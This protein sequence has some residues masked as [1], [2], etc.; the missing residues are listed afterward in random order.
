[1]FILWGYPPWI[2]FYAFMLFFL[3]LSI[4][5]AVVIASAWRAWADREDRPPQNAEISLKTEPQ[6][7]GTD[8]PRIRSGYLPILLLILG[9]VWVFV[10]GSLPI[11]VFLVVSIVGGTAI[12][13][14][15]RYLA[16]HRPSIS[17]DQSPDMTDAERDT[18]LEQNDRD[19]L[20]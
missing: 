6:G 8:P 3:L 13:M 10:K 20:Q 16:G 1:M 2:N 7:W 18:T 11:R 4:V 12:T 15:I 14:L 17:L 19:Y 5:I 9:A